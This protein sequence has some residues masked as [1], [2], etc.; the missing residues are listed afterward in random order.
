[1][2]CKYSCYRLIY[3][4]SNYYQQNNKTKVYDVNTK[5]INNPVITEQPRAIIGKSIE[6]A[7][8][9]WIKGID[10]QKKNN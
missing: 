1:M 8:D 4:L 5:V 9:I 10:P 3:K 2:G 6:N 7:Y